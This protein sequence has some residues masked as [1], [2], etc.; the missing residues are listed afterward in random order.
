MAGKRVSRETRRLCI[1]LRRPLS[2]PL[3]HPSMR[4]PG[5]RARP[6]L[7]LYPPLRPQAHRT[8]SDAHRVPLRLRSHPLLSTK[9]KPGVSKEGSRGASGGF[10]SSRQQLR[11]RHFSPPMTV[12]SIHS[13]HPCWLVAC[14][15]GPGC[16]GGCC[17][18]RCDF[19]APSAYNSSLGS[20][21]I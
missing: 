14:W 11:Y 13:C 17:W 7:L 20:G 10:A 19:D 15:W 12:L 2:K 21:S 9:N 8:S 4:L 3:E 5:D 6:G 1:H 16:W 18:L